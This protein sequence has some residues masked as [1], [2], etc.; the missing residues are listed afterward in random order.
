MPDHAAA[1]N[2]ATVMSDTDPT[3]VELAR[4]ILESSGMEAFVFDRHLSALYGAA[5][6]MR[7]VVHAEDADDALAAL[8]RFG[9]ID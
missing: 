5:L 2:L 7:L 4:S 8:K 3:K 9:F 6:P 1:K